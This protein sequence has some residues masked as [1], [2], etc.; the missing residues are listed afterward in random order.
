MST[1]FKTIE[2]IRQQGFVGFIKMGELFMDQSRIPDTPGAYM[3][4]YSE[5]NTPLF[6]NPGTG[7]FHKGKNPNVSSSIL[8]GNWVKDTIV[9][10]I[11]KVGGSSS[12]A[13]LK[14][15]LRQYLRF[16]QGANVGHFGGRYIWQ[17][18]N[19]RNLIVCWK[20]LLSEKPRDMESKLIQEFSSQYGKRP[21]ANLVN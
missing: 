18:K 11:G 1:K 4:L 3:V 17:I 2:D 15:R 12:D 7:G 6:I 19:S 8:M 20:P 13:T 16:G 10:Y 14:K 5:S 9:V 21:F